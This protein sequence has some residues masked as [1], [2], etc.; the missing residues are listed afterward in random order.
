M[1]T[2]MKRGMAWFA[3]NDRGWTQS[4]ETPAVLVERRGAIVTLVLN[5]VSSP[6]RLEAPRSFSFGLHPIPVKALEPNWRLSPAYSNVFPDAFCGN[7][8]KGRPG[9][10][11]FYLYPEDDWE[12]VKRRINGE[13]LTKGA[14]GLKASYQ[15]QLKQLA[16]QGVS[17]PLPVQLTVPGLYWDM[18]WNGIPRNL[19]HTREW[20]ETWAPDYQS[21]TPEFID[22]ASWCWSEWIVKTD[23]FI[24]GAY[25]DD[26]WGAPQTVAEG[27]NCYKLADGAV[28][29]GYQFRAWRERFKRMRR[30]MAEH[31]LGP[32]LTAHTT[33]TFFIPY[34]S[35]FDLILDGEDFYS[36]P[37]QQ[38]DFIDH[39]PPDRLRFMHNAKWGLI[40]T[41][42]GW[43]GNSLQT[44]KWPAWTFRQTRAWQAH[45]AQ[46]DIRFELPETAMRDF[47]LR[48]PDV[49]FLPYWENEKIA[50]R[51][52]P[53][54]YVT[55]WRR[56]G[57]CLVLIVNMG[58]E[59]QEGEIRFDCQALGFANPA[60]V[61]A[62]DVD[63]DLLTYFDEDTTTMETP[64][65]MAES[66]VKEHDEEAIAF[67]KTAKGETDIEHLTLEI[68]KEDLPL[69]KR[70]AEDPD[71]KFSWDTGVLR[72]PVRRHDYRLFLLAVE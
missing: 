63:P 64:K 17:D 34:H 5:V 68:R 28:Q 38:D 45:L 72:C 39:W 57:K 44:Q 27:L 59:R 53:D 30:I 62:R 4:V 37:P 1:L 25:I 70:R 36:K 7:N 24:R 69:E 20:A 21:Y 42:L 6:V 19:T 22:F 2:G 58:K 49:E 12:A 16:A 14:A 55:I 10:T 8:L 40:T 11:A 56:K 52:S 41:W 18:Q 3:E 26:C 29:P 61:R 66:D 23:K 48:Q 51:K 71:G 47:G 15:N 32:H 67:E 46:H 31:G 13:G 50:M 43:C 9:P 65:T 54:L 35:F 33:H 60:A